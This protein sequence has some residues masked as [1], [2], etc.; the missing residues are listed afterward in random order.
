MTVET[1]FDRRERMY[2]Y[3]AFLRKHTIAPIPSLQV[4]IKACDLEPVPTSNATQA[5]RDAWDRRL[6]GARALRGAGR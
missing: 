4:W 6:A 2:L 1:S 5:E 3:Y